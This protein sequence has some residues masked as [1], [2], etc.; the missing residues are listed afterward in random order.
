LNSLFFNV[1]DVQEDQEKKLEQM[2]WFEQVLM[3]SKPDTK[4]IILTHIYESSGYWAGIPKA[5]WTEKI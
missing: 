4:F 1:F 5:H 2:E 3:T